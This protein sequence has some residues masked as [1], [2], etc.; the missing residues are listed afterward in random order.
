MSAT[1]SS[2][3]YG[4]LN[5]VS[6]FGSLR[7]MHSLGISASFGD[8]NSCAGN[9]PP[10]T[11]VVRHGAATGGVAFA[12]RSIGETDAVALVKSQQR[13]GAGSATAAKSAV[14]RR[15]FTVYV[16]S[17]GVKTGVAGYQHTGE[18]C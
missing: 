15:H 7:A 16:S 4:N 5:Q 13:T 14:R 10:V 2:G 3:N 18:R 6:G 8:D 1:S 11:A 9:I 17:S 12:P